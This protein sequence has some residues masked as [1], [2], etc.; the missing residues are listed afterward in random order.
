MSNPMQTPG[1]FSWSE[2]MT[3]DPEAAMQFYGDLFCWQMLPIPMNDVDYNVVQNGESMI[4]GIMPIPKDAPPGM[5]P[6]WGCYVTV[7]DCDASANKAVELGGKIV[8]GPMDIENVG[9]MAVIQDP[10]G[11]VLSI[12]A[13]FS[14]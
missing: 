9:R 2:L 4:G 13:Y 3:T 1:A 14:A 7:A 6:G 12:I 8:A 5:P 11:A 10:Q